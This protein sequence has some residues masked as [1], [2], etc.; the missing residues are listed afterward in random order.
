MLAITRIVFVSIF[1][2]VEIKVIGGDE[3]KEIEA[4]K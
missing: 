2:G 4:E 3:F 1:N